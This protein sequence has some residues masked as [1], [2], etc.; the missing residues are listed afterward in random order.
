M[1]ETL[2]DNWQ[3]VAAILYAALNLANA[4]IKDPEAKGA[5]GKLIDALSFLTRSGAKGT[6]KA[7]LLH[8]SKP[9]NGK[10]AAMLPLALLLI[11]CACFKPASP[12]YTSAK[13]VVLRQTVD[14]T[15]AAVKRV[16]P[17]LLPV[18]AWIFG[19]ASGDAPTD[20][21]VASLSVNGAGAL[22]CAAAQIQNDFAGNLTAGPEEHLKRAAFRTR[23]E[24]WKA[25]N[26]L[27]GVKFSLPPADKPA[28]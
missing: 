24:A 25:K 6:I 14:C 1:I 2:K 10:L 18:A 15:T 4:L 26:G 19:G 21:L 22:G 23:V 7:P 3:L 28:S 17:S 11:G 27:S 8:R 5:V 13:C 16:L 9:V 12:D 20:Q